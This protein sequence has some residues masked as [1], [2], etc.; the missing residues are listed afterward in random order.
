[1][2]QSHCFRTTVSVRI[3]Y[4]WEGGWLPKNRDKKYF[5]PI[6]YTRDDLICTSKGLQIITSFEQSF[7]AY[8][9]CFILLKIFSTRELQVFGRYEATHSVVAIYS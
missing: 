1:M 4:I 8:V 2:S 6:I 7:C 9:W 5:K 3:V